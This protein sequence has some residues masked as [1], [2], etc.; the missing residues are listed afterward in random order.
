MKLDF[1][2]IVIL[3]TIL[4]IHTCHGGVCSDRGD[5]TFSQCTCSNATFSGLDCQFQCS[6]A[7]YWNGTACHCNTGRTGTYCSLLTTFPVAPLIILQSANIGAPV[8]SYQVYKSATVSYSTTGGSYLLS[9]YTSATSGSTLTLYKGYTYRF[10]M[11]TS[12][13]GNDTF[14]IRTARIN[15]NNTL[16]NITYASDLLSSGSACEARGREVVFTPNRTG[17]GLYYICEGAVSTLDVACATVN[18]KNHSDVCNGHG[19]TLADG[20]VCTCEDGTFTGTNCEVQCGGFGTSSGG[21]CTC[22]P[23]HSGV[24]CA[25]LCRNRNATVFD[26][27]S[28]N[29]AVPYTGSNCGSICNGNGVYTDDVCACLPT[30]NGSL[31][32]DLCA[33]QGSIDTGGN[34]AC[35]YTYSGANCGLVCGGH[36]TPTYG[37]QFSRCTCYPPYTGLFC[38]TVCSGAGT[39]NGTVC[40]CVN[41]RTGVHCEYIGSPSNIV[42]VR[43]Y[44]SSI[45]RFVACNASN[46]NCG[47]AHA[48]RYIEYAF[49]TESFKWGRLTVMSGVTYIFHMLPSVSQL[50][51]SD[52]LCLRSSYL[53]GVDSSSTN[54]GAIDGLSSGSACAYDGDII[55]TFTTGESRTLYLCAGTDHPLTSSIC[56]NITVLGPTSTCNGHGTLSSFGGTCTCSADVYTGVGCETTCGGFGTPFSNLSACACDANHRGGL[57][58]VPCNA[59]GTL[60][61]LDPFTLTELC[62]CDTDQYTGDRCEIECTGKGTVDPDTEECV[63]TLAKYGPGTYCEGYRN[64]ID[65]YTNTTGM[66]P[67]CFNDATQTR[68]VCTEPYLVTMNGGTN[69]SARIFDQNGIVSCANM[70]ITLRAGTT[71]L[72]TSYFSD[73]IYLRFTDEIGTEDNSTDLTETNGI[74]CHSCIG[75]EKQT[76][77]TPHASDRFKSIYYCT[78]GTSIAGAPS[79]CG[80]I[81]IILSSA[82]ICNS[83]GTSL[84]GTDHCTCTPPYAGRLCNETCSNGA[85]L[86]N[87]ECICAPGYTGEVCQ[88][89]CN[90]HGD[91]ASNGT[92]VCDPPYTGEVCES[93]CNGAGTASGATCTCSDHYTGTLCDTACGGNGHV[94]STTGECVCNQPYHG[95]DCDH[96]CMDACAGN[97][98]YPSGD[99]PVIDDQC[100]C[101]GL[102]TPPWCAV[103][104]NENDQDTHPEHFPLQPTT[105]R[106]SL[107]I[108]NC[109]CFPHYSQ[110]SRCLE[111]CHGHGTVVSGNC[112]CDDWH[113]GTECQTACHGHGSFS[114]TAVLDGLC[115]CS[116]PWSG[117][118]CQTQCSGHGTVNS[119]MT[120]NCTDHYSGNVCEFEC[121]GHGRVSPQGQCVCNETYFGENCEKFRNVVVA[122]LD[123]DLGAYFY[124]CRNFN[125]TTNVYCNS[126]YLID[127]VKYSPEQCLGPNHPVAPLACRVINVTY[128]QGVGYQT[129]F[130][131][132]LDGIEPIVTV[133]N[134]TSVVSGHL[135]CD[136]EGTI[137]GGFRIAPRRESCHGHGHS[138]GGVDRCACDPGYTDTQCV[139]ACNGL[140]TIVDTV[141]NCTTPWGGPYCNLTCN[142]QGYIDPSDDTRKNCICNQTYSGPS[143]QTECHHHG[144]TYNATLCTCIIDYVG[145]TCDIQRNANPA[146]NYQGELMPSGKCKCNSPYAG[147][148]CEAQLPVG[149]LAECYQSQIIPLVE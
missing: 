33:K 119:A 103:K 118:S 131:V 68:A 95:D 104:C 7:G 125:S 25:T 48:N 9:S 127:I 84:G 89:T 55:V 144:V 65:I 67:I 81:N 52:S 2:S 77:Y 51:P 71:Y 64:R 113:N 20:T 17:L 114:G 96:N 62:I 35:N 105:G 37:F 86:V 57:C 22:D 121:S 24:H 61:F 87:G 136:E 50:A 29:C 73:A 42:L 80:R 149:S 47:E 143:C 60:D 30:Y 124:A 11:G 123:I 75:W 1:L 5:S 54:L 112:V 146:C 97:P 32:Q 49:D 117:K 26:G 14:C 23:Y 82:P 28:C 74:L 18:V 110:A 142:L 36:G 130:T 120:C 43:S 92:C 100:V 106:Y 10:Q 39:W 126:S 6:D 88:D 133:T 129:I 53:P 19:T 72:F 79:H 147:Y 91:R 141:C 134:T 145:A 135:F 13:N 111:A 98:N 38:D 3:V 56:V 101:P 45:H 41:G 58:D 116:I 46:G 12:T 108:G 140:G 69:C 78:D 4:F 109:S 138:P 115:T 59:R 15:H 21:I 44:F 94:D 70:N 31:C 132:S 34:C 107:A 122:Y 99:C 83:H 66:Y 90:K 128:Y 40:A 8:L 27:S 63:C 16:N 76:V 93:I 148:L 85:T 137:C 139:I 102:L